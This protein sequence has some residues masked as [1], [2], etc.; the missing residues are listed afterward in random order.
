MRF[1][2]SFIPRATFGRIAL[3]MGWGISRAIH[4][5]RGQA[6]S[7]FP[8]RRPKLLS[9]A[10]APRLVRD[11]DLLLFRRSGLVARIGRGRHSHAAMAAWWGDQIF[12]LE[13]TPRFGGRAVTLESQ[14]RRY[15]GRIDLFW[16]DPH[17]K[18]PHFDRAGAVRLMKQLA[19]TPYGYR[20]LCRLV[21]RRLPLLRLF[22]PPETEDDRPSDPP[23]ICSQA[24]AWA[25]RVGGAVDPVPLLADR[26]TEPADLARSIFYQYIGTFVP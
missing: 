23:A 16:A 21:L 9:L 2:H 13:V 15:P 3:A 12:L 26:L 17:G 5:A 24:V 11:A 7:D 18:F 14:V 8:G 4:L 10:D 25:T 20:V 6:S 22:L 1:S 19:G